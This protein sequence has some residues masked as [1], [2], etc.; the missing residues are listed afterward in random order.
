MH[1]LIRVFGPPHEFL[2]V[3]ALWLVGRRPRRV[4]RTHVDIPDDLTA[5]QYVFVAAFPAL[6]FGVVALLGVAGLVNAVT[7][8]QSMLALLA[9]FGGGLGLAGTV[10]DIELILLRLQ[11]A[12]GD[13]P[14]HPQA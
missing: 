6:V 13:G 14:P 7:F 11:R 4:T 9:V 2:H 5:R 1:V 12:D 10:N 3:V 8:G